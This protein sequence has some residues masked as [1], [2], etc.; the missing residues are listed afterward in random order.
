M[1]KTK[2][3]YVCSDCGAQTPQ[4]A[5]QCGVCNAWNS[6][7][8]SSQ[9]KTGLK[10]AKVHNF[11]PA[12]VVE[13]LD[14]IRAENIIRIKTGLPE[15][16]RVLGG[17]LVLG[18]VVLLGGGPGIGKS[19]LLM[20]SMNAMGDNAKVL[21]VSGEESTEQV[22]LRAHRLG[23]TSSNILLIA[24]TSLEIIAET[25][26]KEQPQILVVDSIQTLFTSALQ[27]APGSV[28]QVRETAAY[29]VR[30]AKRTGMCLFLIG[31][32]TKEGALA[33]PRI[34]E[35]MVDV[36]LYF[37]GEASDR[38]RLVRAMKNRFGAVNE[39]GVFI[40]EESGLREV[41]NPSAMFISR[42]GSNTAGTAILATQEGTRPLLVELQALVDDNQLANP[43]RVSVGI[44][45]NRLAMLLA[46][47]HRHAG[48]T[49]QNQDVY[50][51]VAGGL[52]IS[53]T[54]SDLALLLAVVSSYRNRPL[55]NDI[56]VFGEVG[57]GGEVR[58]VQ[59]G[60][61]RLNEAAKLG[62][63]RAIIP[64][65]NRPKTKRKDIEVLPVRRLTEALD[66]ID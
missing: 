5:G 25:L 6:L 48:I 38:F 61:D 41:S 29:L 8:E 15:L 42:Q 47:L 39:L 43:R 54:A 17:G 56:V 45:G 50:I 28:S 1:A 46:V 3:V 21:Y 16:D 36:V 11:A 34:L 4:W 9:V 35:H 55:G 13:R 51:N 20:Q 31:H 40:M 53:E 64:Y 24:E 7:V 12:A 63:K 65:A 60:E 57:L 30:W 26:Q 14:T 18:S 37:E 2:I 66:L 59:R 10:T 22:A 19:T 27:S 33:G 32:I 49:M 23:V 62:F 44:D 58:P 52:R